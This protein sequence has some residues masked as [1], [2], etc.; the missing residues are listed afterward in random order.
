MTCPPERGVP[1]I[2][3]KRGVNAVSSRGIAAKSPRV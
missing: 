2:V 1:G 3:P